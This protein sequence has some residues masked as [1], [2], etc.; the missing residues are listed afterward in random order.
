M[1][2]F[3]QHK[4]EAAAMTQKQKDTQESKPDVKCEGSVLENVFLFKYLGSIF[5]A[6][7]SHAH[8]VIRRVTLAMKRCDQLR[9]VFSSP[10]IPL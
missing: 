10:D 6:D 7:D 9:Q 4:A 8:D 3:H 1:F 5:A 2:Y